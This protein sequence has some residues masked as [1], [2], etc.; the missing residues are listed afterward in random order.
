MSNMYAK[1][2]AWSF[3]IMGKN[4]NKAYRKKKEFTYIHIEEY[5][6]AIKKHV[7]QKIFYNKGKMLMI[8]EK[9]FTQYILNFHSYEVKEQEGNMQAINKCL[10]LGR[11]IISV[12]LF[13]YFSKFLQWTSTLS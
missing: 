6:S 4:G 1:S 7:Q 5:Y 13:L 9:N 10:S 8:S 3:I 12:L 11:E 2:I